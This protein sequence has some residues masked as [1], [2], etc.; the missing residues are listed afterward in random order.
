[1]GEPADTLRMLV[2][3]YAEIVDT[4]AFGAFDEVFTTE[5]VLETGN[6]RRVGL[7]EIRTAMQGLHRYEATDH[8]VG[9][10]TFAID[11]DRATGTVECEAHHWST[12]DS[13]HRTDRVMT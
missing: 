1:M 8:Q 13:G 4:R 10:S 5:A 12:N 11:G 9:A 3:R 6:G 2:R 7:D